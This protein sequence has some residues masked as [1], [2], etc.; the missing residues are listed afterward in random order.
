ML[1]VML[2]SI[3][4]KIMYNIRIYKEFFYVIAHH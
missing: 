2:T 3:C 4:I 1:I